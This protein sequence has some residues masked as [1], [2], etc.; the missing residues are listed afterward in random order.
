M[1][2][3][4]ALVP[5]HSCSSIH[6][7]PTTRV[8]HPLGS[9]KKKDLRQRKR[10]SKAEIERDDMKAKRGQSSIAE[11][12]NANKAAR[13]TPPPTQES[14]GSDGRATGVSTHAL[15]LEVVWRTPPTSTPN[16]PHPSP[17]ALFSIGVARHGHKCACWQASR[18]SA[19]PTLSKGASNAAANAATPRINAVVPTDR[20]RLLD[21]TRGEKQNDSQTTTLPRERRKQSFQSARLRWP[22]V[23]MSRPR[24]QRHARQ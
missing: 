21:Q 23:G 10:R 20:A 17:I 16:G 14:Q 13:T 24:T 12:F 8:F 9:G 15:S 22:P 3:G 2:H 6:R 11:A 4:E 5:A 7:Y 1:D 18:D 19:L